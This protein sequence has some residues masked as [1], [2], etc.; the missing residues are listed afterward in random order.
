MSRLFK[1]S[2][3]LCTAR[4]DRILEY[5]SEW[6]EAYV[7]DFR[8]PDGPEIEFRE[9]LPD[10]SDYTHDGDKNKL[11]ILDDLMRQACME[12]VSDLFPGALTTKI[13][14][15][16]TSRKISSARENAREI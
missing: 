13:C 12:V 5:Y 8:I 16:S 11:L 7:Q 4:F 6:Q 14:R 15:Y 3:D 1:N 10:T 2:R 9:G